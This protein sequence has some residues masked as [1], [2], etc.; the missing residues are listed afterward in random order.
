VRVAPFPDRRTIANLR[1]L[2]DDELLRRLSELLHT[3]RRGESVLVAHIGEVDQRKLYAREAAPSMFAYCTDVLHLSEQEAYLR[4]T[5]A[6]AAREHPVLLAMLADG[7]LHLTAIARLAPHLTSENRMAVLARAVHKSKRQVEELVAEI[8]PRPDA[9][10][11]VRKLPEPRIAAAAPASP[12]PQPPVP[13]ES[14][15][16]RASPAPAPSAQRPATV[17]PTAPARYKV[18]FTASAEFRDKLDRLV[19]LMRRRV[20]DGNLAAILEEAVTEKLRRL[21]ARRF[22]RTTSPRP[23]VPTSDTSGTRSRYVAAAIRRAADARDGGQCAYTGPDG[24][25]CTSRERLEFDHAIAH[26]RG[27]DRSVGNIRLMCRTHNLYLAER[28]Y[29]KEIMARYRRR[30]SGTQATRGS[31]AR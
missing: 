2:S 8:S 22:G 31:P 23:S 17:E 10:A 19:A 6:R 20:P 28:V 29:G 5:V 4:I 14:T 1:S 7:R 18:Q 30:V 11:T 27:G 13:A 9:P 26:G 3:S 15:P 24:R 21:E 12:E 16:E 25:R